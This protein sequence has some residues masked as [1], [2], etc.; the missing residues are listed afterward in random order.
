M[1]NLSVKFVSIY[2]FILH[3]WHS[4]M[5]KQQKKSFLFTKTNLDKKSWLSL[6]FSAIGVDPR[7]WTQL[8]YHLHLGNYRWKLYFVLDKLCSI[9]TDKLEIQAICF[10]PTPK[11]WIS[12]I[13]DSCKHMETSLIPTVNDCLQSRWWSNSD[14]RLLA[15]YQPQMNIGFNQ[16]SSQI[17]DINAVIK[18]ILVLLIIILC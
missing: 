18:S 17:T 7:F 1:L 4:T 2:C 5:P 12:W 8:S 6:F 13:F 9:F 14:T 16:T 15:W 11:H 10:L 3:F